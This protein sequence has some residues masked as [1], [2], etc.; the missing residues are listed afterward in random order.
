MDAI[1]DFYIFELTF[2]L[3]SLSFNPMATVHVILSPLANDDYVSDDD[4]ES[5]LT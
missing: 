5:S 4:T 1:L 2:L 3:Y